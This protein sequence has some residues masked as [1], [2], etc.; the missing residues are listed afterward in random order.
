MEEVPVSA[1]LISQRMMG[2]LTSITR[3][4]HLYTS[5]KLSLP[6][7]TPGY[8]YCPYSMWFH[9]MPSPETILGSHI[10]LTFF[11]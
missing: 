5:L 2:S 7:L 1:E 9:F 3:V 10:P 11:L 8:L 4:T 6:Y